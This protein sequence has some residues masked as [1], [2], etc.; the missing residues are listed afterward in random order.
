MN[1]SKV[2]K[3]DVSSVSHPPAV[4]ES[5]TLRATNPFLNETPQDVQPSPSTPSG[6]S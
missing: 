4:P 3:L 6:L 1:F 5:S 2:Q